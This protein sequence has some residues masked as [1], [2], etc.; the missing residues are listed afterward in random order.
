[1]LNN[2][3]VKKKDIKCKEVFYVKGENND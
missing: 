2:K 3:N 1:L